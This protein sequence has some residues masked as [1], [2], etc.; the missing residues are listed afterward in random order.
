MILHKDKV[1]FGVKKVQTVHRIYSYR[2]SGPRSPK[3]W[4]PTSIIKRAAEGVPETSTLTAGFGRTRYYGGG[5]TTRFTDYPVRRVPFVIRSVYHVVRR[6]PS[7]SSLFTGGG[8]GVWAGHRRLAR[9]SYAVCVH[10]APPPVRVPQPPAQKPP[11]PEVYKHRGQVS[12]GVG[13]GDYGGQSPSRGAEF[14]SAGG[15]FN[16]DC[17]SHRRYGRG[18]R[19]ITVTVNRNR[20]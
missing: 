11:G 3:R 14:G 13:S 16:G 7:Y 2:F 12:A 15:T 10:V 4:R 20:L 17:P 19:A 18:R 8:G 6:R 9:P 5:D 1:G